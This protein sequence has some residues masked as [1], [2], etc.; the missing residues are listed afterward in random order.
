MIG[1]NMYSIKVRDSLPM[2]LVLARSLLMNYLSA[3][4]LSLVPMEN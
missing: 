3:F 4:F 1:N 2:R